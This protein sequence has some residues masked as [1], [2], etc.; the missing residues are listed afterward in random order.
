MGSL[1]LHMFDISLQRSEWKKWIHQFE[2]C[3]SVVFCVDLS[4][5]DCLTLEESN[6]S[7]IMK[8]LHLFNAV[9]NSQW[10]FRA[11]IILLLCNVRHFKEK[12]NSKPLSDYFP[13]YSGGNDVNKASKYLLWQFN[14]VNRAHLNICPQLCEPSDNFNMRL[15]WLAVKETTLLN[16]QKH[17]ELL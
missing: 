11:S 4:Q 16:A 13:D 7:G 10:F 12:L 2:D 5:Y 3:I 14:Q 6:K 8:S 9:V 17:P 15:V 1:S